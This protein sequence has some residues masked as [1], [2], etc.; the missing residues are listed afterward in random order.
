[1]DKILQH[2]HR[3]PIVF[4]YD[5][6]FQ[7]RN[8]YISPLFRNTIFKSCPVIPLAFLIH[9][10][11]LRS[12]HE[13]L[14]KMVMSEVPFLAHGSQK[15]PIVTDNEKAFLALSMIIF[16]NAPDSF[17][18]TMPLILQSYGLDDMVQLPLKYQFMLAT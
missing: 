5:T 16:H 12:C 10:K 4:S 18:G 2:Q 11:K 14:M 3:I 8:F 9:Q 17:V 15:Y 1:M 13:K 6:T 7:L